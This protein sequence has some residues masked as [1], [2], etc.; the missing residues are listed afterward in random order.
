MPE[1]VAHCEPGQAQEIEDLLAPVMARVREVGAAHGAEFSNPVAEAHSII[2]VIAQ[3]A[4]KV[5]AKDNSVSPIYMVPALMC[6]AAMMVSQAPPQNR[7]A[8]V[9]T[10]CSILISTVASMGAF[11]E[12]GGSA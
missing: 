2:S 4:C 3:A 5:A 10:L 8:M 6:G 1:F 9:E 12:P 11:D 7:P